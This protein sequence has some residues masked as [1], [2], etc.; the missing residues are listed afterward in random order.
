MTLDSGNIRFMRLFAVI[1]KIYVN[2]PQIYVCLLSIY[3]GM[4]CRSRCQDLVFSRRTLMTLRA[5]LF[6]EL[7]QC[8]C[9]H[10]K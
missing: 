6:L 8:V 5:E 1:L 4:V 7:D 2:F 9:G 10:F 3:T